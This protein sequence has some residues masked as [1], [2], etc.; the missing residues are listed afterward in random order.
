MPGHWRPAKPEALSRHWLGRLVMRGFDHCRD[1]NSTSGLQNSTD[2]TRPFGSQGSAKLSIAYRRLQLSSISL[3]WTQALAPTVSKKQPTWKTCV[4][5]GREMLYDSDLPG[6]R[7]PKV[8][9]YER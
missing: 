5:E 1:L 7:M 4:W 2:S 3:S 6:S 8:A 9:R